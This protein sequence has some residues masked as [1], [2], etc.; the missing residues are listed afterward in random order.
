MVQKYVTKV[1]SH[2]HTFKSSQKS[3]LEDEEQELLM[4][5][6]EYPKKALVLDQLPWPINKYVKKNWTIDP[7]TDKNNFINRY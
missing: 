5:L 4:Y 1:I 6:K 3:R 2:F 7:K